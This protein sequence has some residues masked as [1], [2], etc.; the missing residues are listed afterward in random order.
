VSFALTIALL[1]S[2]VA[3]FAQGKQDGGDMQDRGGRHGKRH[4]RGHGD[5][6]GRFARNLNLT[7]A[8]KAQLQQIAD[9]H[10]AS[11]QGLREQ[12]RNL[13]R[14]SGTK[15]DDGSFNEAAV[16]QAAQA[17]ANLMVEFEVAR[18]RMKS[19]MFAVLTAEQKAQLAQQRAERKQRH[20]ERRNRRGVEGKEVQQ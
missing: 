10:K 1:V 19:E 4:G 13:H 2:A 15:A 7:D 12:M 17:R 18:A 8:Q 3:G 14:N 16:R 9:R 5:G 20:Q 6:F 11:T